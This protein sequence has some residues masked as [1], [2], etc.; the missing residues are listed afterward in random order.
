MA[1]DVVE[2]RQRNA[3]DELH[4]Y[5]IEEL[6]LGMSALYARTVTDADIVLFAGIS[7]DGNPVHL[8]SEFAANTV[9]EG[10]IAHGM[11]TASFVSTVLGTKLPGPGCVY[12]SQSLRFK[13]PVRAGDTVNARVTITDIVPAKRKVTL[14][15]VCTVGE[16]VVLEGEAVVMV[17]A[18][19]AS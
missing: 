19:P 12:L 8:N 9:F 5:Y 17:P 10:R 7:G 13:A 1:L 14:A 18:R 6:A 15:T 3:M 11:L 2:E 4:G 16:R